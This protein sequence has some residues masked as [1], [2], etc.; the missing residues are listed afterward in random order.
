MAYTAIKM[1]RVDMKHVTHV[2]NTKFKMHMNASNQ[3]ESASNLRGVTDHTPRLSQTTTA[4]SHTTPSTF[5]THVDDHM[6]H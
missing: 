3:N 6:P 5:E 1:L 2:Q 4:H